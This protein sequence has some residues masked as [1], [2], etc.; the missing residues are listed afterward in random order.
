MR[1]KKLQEKLSQERQWYKKE[2][3]A[4]DKKG[5]EA[6]ELKAELVKIQENFA[7]EHAINIRLQRE[8]K[9][10]NQQIDGLRAQ[11]REVDGENIRLK[12]KMEVD[13]KEMA[14]LKK[15]VVELSKKEEDT[16]WIAKS[17]YERVTRLLSQKEKELQ[18]MIR[19]RER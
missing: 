6:F 4:A 11:C 8:L 13:Q 15:K 5:E 17:E 1:V 19:E 3:N 14:Q 9:E 12:T 2:Q 7:K 10:S 16:Q 18:R